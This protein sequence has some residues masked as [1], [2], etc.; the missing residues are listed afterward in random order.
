MA[1]SPTQ[2]KVRVNRLAHLQCI[3]L[4]LQNPES[5]EVGCLSGHKSGCILRHPC[6]VGLSGRK[7]LLKVK[8]I[9][10]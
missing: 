3:V 4:V 7:L 9:N 1:P 2:S 5:I 6:D 10:A 8:F